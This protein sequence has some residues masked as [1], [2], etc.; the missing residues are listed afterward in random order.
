MS[1][2]WVI[3]A[4]FVNFATSLEE[5]DDRNPGR[6]IARGFFPFS[7]TILFKQRC[8]FTEMAHQRDWSAASTA[9]TE[10]MIRLIKTENKQD[11]E[12]PAGLAAQ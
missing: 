12:K 5:A 9:A 4:D 8:A 10:Q 2:E 11:V 7:A 6:K 1:K 3:A